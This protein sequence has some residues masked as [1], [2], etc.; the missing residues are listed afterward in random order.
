MA[1]SAEAMAAVCL[2]RAVSNGL[3]DQPPHFALSRTYLVVCR[4]IVAS[5]TD[6]ED[7]V[8]TVGWGPGQP[9]LPNPALGGLPFGIGTAVALDDLEAERYW[10]NV[11]ATTLF[12]GPFATPFFN[13]FGGI[14]QYLAATITLT[15]L[16]VPVGN[17]GGSLAQGGIVLNPLNCL[18]KMHEEAKAEELMVVVLERHIQEPEGTIP[19]PITQQP[20]GL[21][22]LFSQAQILLTSVA[23]NLAAELLNAT[24][25]GFAVVGVTNPLDPPISGATITTAIS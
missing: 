21:G 2:A 1:L 5:L 6:P 22:D 18:N 7:V 24:Q 23:I 14:I 3:V 9:A 12:S 13:G 17:G 11:H 16:F 25:P 4:G 15:D 8:V 20:L 10:P 19:D